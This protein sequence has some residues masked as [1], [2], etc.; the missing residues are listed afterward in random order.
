[1]LIGA[2]PLETD[3]IFAKMA[4]IKKNRAAKA[5][6]DNALWDPQRQAS[7]ASRVWRSAA[8]R[9]RAEAGKADQR[10]RVRLLYVG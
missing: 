2:D 3:A 5:L 6:I 7:S 4:R 1:M 9:Q 10:H 8:R